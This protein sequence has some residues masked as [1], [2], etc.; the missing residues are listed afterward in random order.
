[1]IGIDRFT[2]VTR[3]DALAVHPGYS[4]FM[5]MDFPDGSPNFLPVR[6]TE[7]NGDRVV[8]QTVGGRTGWQADAP[9]SMFV[10][11]SA[12]KRVVLDGRR[13]WVWLDGGDPRK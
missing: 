4:A 7:V 3:E 10:P 11:T 9:R 6:I 8:Y 1:M 13:R 5:V 2:V 12:V